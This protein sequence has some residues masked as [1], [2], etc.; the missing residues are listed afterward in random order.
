M[1]LSAFSIAQD[2]L[3]HIGYQ[4]GGGENL[5]AGALNYLVNCLNQSLEEMRVKQ[6]LMFRQT[7]TA[8]FQGGRGGTVNVTNDSTALTLGTLTA[9]ANGST[10]VIGGDTC[11]NEIRSD[12]QGG[13]QLLVPYQGP[14]S[15]QGATCYGD[16]IVLDT[17]FIDHVMSAALLHDRRQISVLTNR[18]EWLAAQTAY[19]TGDYTAVGTGTGPTPSSAPVVRRQPSVPESVWLYTHQ[20]AGGLPEYQVRV[21]PLPSGHW[22]VDLDVA[23]MPNE[24][25]AE[26]LQAGADYYFPVPGGRVYTIFRALALYHWS[27]S[28]FFAN[29]AAR[30]VINQGYQDATTQLENFRPHV[31]AQPRV[32]VKGYL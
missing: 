19:W 25:D 18:N 13:W 26:D 31:A 4:I 2:C 14:T 11:Y 28:P 8:N 7:I 32:V 5:Q 29:Q 10:I 1:P 21:S 15:T 12:G 17:S 9:P 16:S 30:S 24:V 3:A 20:T 22:A 27:G 23:I 6:P